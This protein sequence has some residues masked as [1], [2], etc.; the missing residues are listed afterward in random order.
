MLA[1]RREPYRTGTLKRLSGSTTL[2]PKTSFRTGAGM[3]HRLVAKPFLQPGT[4]A[5]LSRKISFTSEKPQS[6]STSMWLPAAKQI[7]P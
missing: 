1:S 7:L 5:P 4:P 2:R 3:H 6:S